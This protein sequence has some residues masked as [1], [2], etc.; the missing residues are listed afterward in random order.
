MRLK[1]KSVLVTG[2]A[3]FI[4][5]HLVDELIREEAE[6]IIVVDN[7]FLGKKGNL[8]HAKE[9]FEDLKVYEEDAA[10][11]KKMKE[12]IVEGDVDVIFNLAVIPLPTSFTKP[13]W[14][15]EV[16]VDITLAFCDLIKEGCYD[17]LIHCSSSEAYG[18]AQYIPMDEKHPLNPTT[19]YAA[20]K[21]ASDHLVFSYHE[22]FGIDASIVRPFNNYGP[23]QNDKAYAGVIPTTI[24][25]ILE[26]KPPIIFGDGEQTRDYIYATD[27]AK[28]MIE[29][30]GNKKTRGKVINIA[31]GQ[32]I[33]INK[34]IKMIME[35]LAYKKQPI[36]KEERSA[37]VLR[38]LAD[39]SLAEELLGF[40][41]SVDFE[42][43]LT[44][45]VEWY[46]N[47]FRGYK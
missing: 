7:F 21:A 45:T 25:R 14:T 11:S 46:K 32:E 27:T 33:S 26:D 38:H 18:S 29:V 12:I 23:R 36:Y 43:G 31:S 10:D 1:N 20:S 8:E 6:E 30:Y 16:N 41:N 5:S 15:F 13:R 40:K 17:T 28:A 19:P 35:K 34:L 3:G 9:S 37:D 47:Y 39:I 4:G 44:E 22:T 24:K 42:E 2:G